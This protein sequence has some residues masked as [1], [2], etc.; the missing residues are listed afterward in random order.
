MNE[1]IS[2]WP[3]AESFTLLPPERLNEDHFR[4][5]IIFSRLFSFLK[6]HQEDSNSNIR[7]FQVNMDRSA[8]TFNV[9]RPS[10]I[11]QINIPAGTGGGPKFMAWTNWWTG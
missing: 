6:F 1:M 4:Q 8:G 10:R 7:R 5:Q 3:T 9:Q 11:T 2:H